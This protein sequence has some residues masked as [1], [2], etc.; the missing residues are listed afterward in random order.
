M[1]FL[2]GIPYLAEVLALILAAHALAI[3]VVNLTPTPKDDE[4]VAFI[5]KIIEYVA[6]I[7]TPKAKE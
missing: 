1:E 3:A 5:Y 6:G 2:S 4:A 7:I